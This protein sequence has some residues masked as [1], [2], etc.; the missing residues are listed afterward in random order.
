MQRTIA[1][2]SKDK[3][4][5]AIIIVNYNGYIDTAE[6]IE[7]IQ[8][9]TYFL[10]QIIV[11][12]NK[13]T[14]DSVDNLK[15]YQNI[16]SFVL[17][18]INDNRGFSA[19][20]NFGIKYAIDQQFDYILLLNNDTLVDSS[21]LHELVKTEEIYFDKAI[22]TS[23]I[24]YAYDKDV[25]WYAGGKFNKITSRTEHIGIHEIDQGQYDTEKKVS[26]ISGCCMFFPCES[27]N[28][29]GLMDE[30][31]FLYCEDTD[32][33]CRFVEAGF[34]LVYQPKAIL[35]HKVNSSTAKMSDLICYYSVRNKL[36][37]IHK[38]INTRV[39]FVAYMYVFL[40]TIKR[41]IK[42]EYS[43]DASKKAVLDYC[44]GIKGKSF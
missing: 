25:L 24:Y 11:V 30:D 10:Y 42:K 9:S 36:W 44:I 31:Y 4:R 41:I 20:N 22:I 19:G 12:D 28:V 3:H 1:V 7:S 38:F 6:C 34:D 26:L 17:L 33:G 29:I 15:K 40:E 5:I 37:I 2:N 32:Y 16:Y 13:S 43:F 14:D 35:Y 21:L 39:R 8:K 18:E 27:V 23:K